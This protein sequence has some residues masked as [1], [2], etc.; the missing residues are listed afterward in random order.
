M[1]NAESR[2]HSFEVDQEKFS[3]QRAVTYFLLLLFSITTGFVM[4][5]NDQSER[6]M[7]LQTIINLTLLAV[8]Y[9]LGASKQGQDQAQ[10]AQRIAEAV[11][12]AVAAAVK[13]AVPVVTPGPVTA[14]GIVPAAEVVKGD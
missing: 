2:K 11:P 10:S 9:W 1:S 4:W 12:A 6:S 7:V 3:T 8:G 13:P 5:Q 14:D